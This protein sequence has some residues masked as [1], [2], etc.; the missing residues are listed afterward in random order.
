MFIRVEGGVLFFNLKSE[1]KTKKIDK[2]KSVT[3]YL[4]QEICV[5][6]K[7]R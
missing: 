1:N 6:V 5:D 3:F 7:S 4:F 2:Y